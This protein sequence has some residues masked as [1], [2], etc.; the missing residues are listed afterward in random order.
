MGYLILDKV[1]GDTQWATQWYNALRFLNDNAYT[2]NST[3]T[4]S[5]KTLT[6]PTINDDLA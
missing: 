6:N 2:S 4:L 1:Q 3:E 5:N